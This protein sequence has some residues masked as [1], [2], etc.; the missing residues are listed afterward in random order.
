[1]TSSTGLRT[2]RLMTAGL[3]L[4]TSVAALNANGTAHAAQPGDAAWYSTVFQ[5]GE[6][7]YHTYRVPA[8]VQAADGSLLAFAEGRVASA[9]DNGDIDLV[10]KRSEDG[11]A[12]WGPLEVVVDDGANKFGNPVPVLDESTGQIVLNATRTGGDVS[13]DDIRCGEAE[14][15]EMRRSF[16]LFSDDNGA[17]WTEPVEITADVRP[18]NW[19]HFVGGPGHAIQL[20]RGEHAGRLVLPGNHT[21][22]PPEGSGIDCLDERLYGAHSLYSDDHGQTWH[23]GGVDT[24]LTGV[25]NP[26]ESTAAELSDG[27][28]YFNARDQNGS[29]TGTRAATTSSDGGASFDHPYEEVPDLVAPVVQGSVLSLSGSQDGRLVFSAPGSAAV[30]ENLTLSTSDD[31]ATTWQAGPVIHE[32]PAGYSDLVEVRDPADPTAIGVLY[33]NGVPTTDDPIPPYYQR[34]SFAHLPMEMLP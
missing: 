3:V 14:P 25:I 30:R 4:A 21:I 13:G 18:D 19:R 8:M 7:G 33:E 11:G 1:M 5:Q 20:T 34:I 26:N 10:M 15:E 27:T 9:S 24:P 28:V 22:A 29:S 6:D 2:A 17:T 12:T 23:L 16:I 32:G 31:N